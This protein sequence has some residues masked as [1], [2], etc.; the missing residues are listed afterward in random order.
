MHTKAVFRA[1]QALNDAGFHV[2]RFNFRGVGT[3]TGTHDHGVGEA[4]DARAALDW[5]EAEHPGLPLLLGGFSFGAMVALRVGY[6]EARVQALLGLGLPVGLYDLDDLADPEARGGRPLLLVQGEEDE[7]G[8]GAELEAFA[9][10]MG[11]GVEVARIGGA[12]HYFH[13]RLD[14]LRA[15]VE[16]FFGR[17]AGSRIFPVQAGA[18][19]GAP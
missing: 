17:G 8:S 7:F 4:D 1:A 2:L 15:A 13:D 6:G 18:P 16:T 10:R 11:T 14:Q 9:G 3:S 19:E 12:D 5:L